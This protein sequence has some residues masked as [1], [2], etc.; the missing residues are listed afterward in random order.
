MF[1]SRFFFQSLTHKWTAPSDM[2]PCKTEFNMYVHMYQY[3]FKYYT[4]F[5]FNTYNENKHKHVY[6]DYNIWLM[7]TLSSIF[8]FKIQTC[9]NKFVNRIN[10]IIKIDELV[11]LSYKNI[12]KR[13]I[14]FLLKDLKMFK[15]RKVI[16]KKELFWEAFDYSRSKRKF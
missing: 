9:R 11:F 13:N 1:F 2:S 3:R 16:R 8:L 15:S 12:L 5:G 14:R 10:M 6:L 4:Y 7:F